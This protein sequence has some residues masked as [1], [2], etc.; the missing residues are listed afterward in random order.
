[1][2]EAGLLDM[3]DGL[4]NFS[5]RIKKRKNKMWPLLSFANG[6]LGRL[7]T[8]V[9]TACESDGRIKPC[10]NRAGTLLGMRRA[11]PYWHDSL[12]YRAMYPLKKIIR[13]SD[14]HTSGHD[15]R[16]CPQTVKNTR[17]FIRRYKYEKS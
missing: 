5:V 3:T 6:W 13:N 4:H 2:A 10:S 14:F 11:R 16:K 15:P 7:I 1:M 8:H 9:I 17:P 12:L